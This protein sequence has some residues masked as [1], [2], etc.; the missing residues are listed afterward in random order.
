MNNS[1]HRC[2]DRVRTGNGKPCVLPAR[3]AAPSKETPAQFVAFVA[4]FDVPRLDC[5]TGRQRYKPPRQ[6]ESQL[7]QPAQRMGVTTST[8]PSD[9]RNIASDTGITI[10]YMDPFIRWAEDWKV[11]L[12]CFE[13]PFDIVGFNENDDFRMASALEVTCF[14][15]WSEFA[16]GRYSLWQI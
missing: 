5:P 1:I 7:A 4:D 13:F 2:T 11:Q 8:S 3:H 14:T 6:G 15:A 9:L 10:T 16:N 12:Q